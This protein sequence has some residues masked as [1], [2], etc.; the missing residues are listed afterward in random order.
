MEQGNVS[1]WQF[2]RCFECKI[3]AIM[4]L[5]VN[6]LGFEASDVARY[7]LVLSMSLGKRITPMVSVVLVLKYKDLVNPL[8]KRPKLTEK[9]NINKGLRCIVKMNGIILNSHVCGFQAT[10]FGEKRATQ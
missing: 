1:R 4:D 7:P 8:S 6:K 5:L 9:P 10:I 3:E 2:T